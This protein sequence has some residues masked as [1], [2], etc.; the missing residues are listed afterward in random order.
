[1]SADLLWFPFKLD[2]QNGN[3]IVA[4]ETEE[5]CNKFVARVTLEASRW[6]EESPSAAAVFLYAAAR[7]LHREAIERE[8][9]PTPA[10]T[11]VALLCKAKIVAHFT[12]TG[13][14]R[15]PKIGGYDKSRDLIS[16]LIADLERLA[17]GAPGV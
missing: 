14:P 11:P 9:I 10:A 7:R 4:E 16:S 2:D 3:T 15:D 6:I 1:M 12:K 17:G 8:G 13:L 5:P